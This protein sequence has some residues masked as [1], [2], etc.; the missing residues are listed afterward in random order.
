MAKLPGIII[1]IGAETRDAIQ[2]INRVDRALGRSASRADRT[3][4]AMS[5]VGKGLLTVGAAA[6]AGAVAIG[7]EGVKAAV[8]DEKATKKLAKTMENLGKA[9]DVDKVEDNIEA[10]M[11]QTGV[12]DDELRPAFEKLVVATGDTDTALDLL[13]GALDTAAGAGK[14]LE[15]V[16]AAIAKAAGPDGAAGALSRLIPGLDKTAIKGGDAEAILAELNKKFRGQAISQAD[17]Y[18]GKMAAISTAFSELQESFG[19]G[20]LGSLDGTNDAM[21]GMDDTLYTLGPA[22]EQLG[23]GLGNVAESLAQIAQYIGPVVEKMQALDDILS[24][25]GGP[26][27]FL[28]GGTLGKLDYITN[29]GR[30]L[31]AAVTGNDAA[32]EAAWGDI[33]GRPAGRD[34]GAFYGSSP[35]SYSPMRYRA[36]AASATARSRSRAAVTDARSNS[37]P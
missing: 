14:P 15:A 29:G 37:R 31:A 24:K 36:N 1:K 10:L 21:G 17:T 25:A 33:Q 4:A 12:A 22:A 19:K 20:L 11:K 13:R 16:T 9:Q 8:D 28:L 7:V 26:T 32:R 18:G 27:D 2:G 5:K 34:W 35:S 23:E 3:R 30:Y 6:A